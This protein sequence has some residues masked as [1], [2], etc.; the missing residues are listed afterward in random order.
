M[1][2]QLQFTMSTPDF[3]AKICP[4]TYTRVYTVIRYQKHDQYMQMILQHTDR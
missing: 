3:N 4:L 2:N 1:T